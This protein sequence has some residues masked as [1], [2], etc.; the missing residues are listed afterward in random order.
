MRVSKSECVK[1]ETIDKVESGS[2]RSTTHSWLLSRA[3]LNGIFENIQ[4]R[5][6]LRKLINIDKD[7]QTDIH[8]RHSKKEKVRNDC[9]AYLLTECL[10]L[11][12]LRRAVGAAGLRRL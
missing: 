2:N 6:L 11:R 5:L 8:L 12:H 9:L 4:T 1:V 7:K 3:H 10:S